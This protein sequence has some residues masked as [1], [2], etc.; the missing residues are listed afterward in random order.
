M[1][2][3][4]HPSKR[5]EIDSRTQGGFSLLEL[6]IVLLI[7]LVVAGIAIPNII[8]EMHTSKM[9]GGVSDFAS[10]IESQRLY[11]IKNNQYYSTYLIPGAGSVPDQVYVDMISKT[12]NAPASGGDLGTGVVSGEPG[13]TGDPVIEV[14]AEVSQQPAASAPNTS[15][16][17]SQ[18]LPSSTTI[19][20]VDASTNPITF[21]PR[22][23]PCVPLAFGTKA[24]CD[25]SG[26]PVTYWTF[27]MNDASNEW[28]ALTVTPAGRIQ[29][30]YFT[31]S[32]WK[33]F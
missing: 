11:A 33:S 16:L 30:W 3:Q 13:T 31:G 7:V 26:G 12:T 15:N 25:N 28:D 32:Q 23:L 21:G 8:G 20:P 29:K 2:S 14:P 10:L 5:L 1:F 9:R 22:G 27:F 19:A 4:I 6:T 24:V 17:K 18:L